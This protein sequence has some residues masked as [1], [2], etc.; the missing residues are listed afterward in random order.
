MESKHVQL[1]M[2]I[3]VIWF[4]RVKPRG[5]FNI[6]MTF[7]GQILVIIVISVKNGVGTCIYVQVHFGDQI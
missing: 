6:K 3:L 5:Y 4:N 2:F 7:Y 1:N